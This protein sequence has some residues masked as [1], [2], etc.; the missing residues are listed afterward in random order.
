MAIV[1]ALLIGLVVSLV[2]E[3]NEITTSKKIAEI[4]KMW[5]GKL[6]AQAISLLPLRSLDKCKKRV[7]CVL[8]LLAQA[9]ANLLRDPNN[10]RAIEFCGS[11][12]VFH[13]FMHV[14][15]SIVEIGDRCS[16]ISEFMVGMTQGI[17]LFSTH[18]PV[19]NRLISCVGLQH[20]T[21]CLCFAVKWCMKEQ[22]LDEG[23]L[24]LADILF[25]LHSSVLCFLRWDD[26]FSDCIAKF[27]EDTPLHAQ[28]FKIMNALLDDDGAHVARN[29]CICRFVAI[30]LRLEYLGVVSSNSEVAKQA[31]EEFLGKELFGCFVS[32]LLRNYGEL[33]DTTQAA[34]LMLLLVG[35]KHEERIDSELQY[36]LRH[37]L[38]LVRRISMNPFGVQVLEHVLG[39]LPGDKVDTIDILVGF[40]PRKIASVLVGYGF[41]PD[42]C[43][44][45][46]SPCHGDTIL[47]CHTCA[48]VSYCSFFCQRSDVK[49]HLCTK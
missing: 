15:T 37:H 12:D 13:H 40:S 18:L 20:V 2:V 24:S 35:I 44:W 48:S 42:C 38:L 41:W 4:K 8:S 47:I 7:R 32:F 43:D 14:F 33:D 27:C 10:A 49:N 3:P 6:L 31:V 46:G 23:L 26:A 9:E 11:D 45:C 5:E 25:V 17:W 30:V 16:L 39:L 22:E 1:V 34:C 19:W 36:Q 29:E 21:E 28:I